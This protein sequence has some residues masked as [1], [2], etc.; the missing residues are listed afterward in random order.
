M[1]IIVMIKQVPETSDVKMDEQSGTMVREGVESIINPLDLYAVE[2]GIKLKEQYGGQVV[3]IT[4]GPPKAEKALREAL[5]MGCDEGILI[6]GKEFAGSDTVATAYVLAQ[7][8]K[9]VG[10]YDLV[11]AGERATDGDTGQVGPGVAAL[12]NL[13][14]STYTSSIVDLV[15]KTITVER[16]TEE[17]YEVLELPMPA[18]LTVVKEISFPRLPTLR[19]KQRA[20]KHEFLRWTAEGMSLERDKLGLRG[21][22]TRVVKI[23]H[24]KVLRQGQI[25]RVTDEETLDKAIDL[26]EKFLGDK[27]IIT[28]E[29]KG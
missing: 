24:P 1:K 27:E 15:D 25:L 6:S 19:G 16:L 10:D 9:M 29:G 8:I 17:G 4:M 13:P 21:S 22:P 3:A 7:A 28:K 20:K 11:L 2:T 5:A 12:L 26:L 23:E 14:L 18:L